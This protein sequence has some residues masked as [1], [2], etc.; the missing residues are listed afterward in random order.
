[1]LNIFIIYFLFIY[2]LFSYLFFIYFVF[3]EYVVLFWMEIKD[4]RNKESWRRNILVCLFFCFW[5]FLSEV[6]EWKK[7]WEEVEE[8]FNVFYFGECILNVSM[9]HLDL[10]WCKTEM[11]LYFCVWSFDKNKNCWT[12]LL[13]IFVFIF[14]LFW[15]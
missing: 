15:I 9:N 5:F 7:K 12:F 1:M 6:E 8:I 11:G 3:R 10:M 4:W 14:D 2:D 13:L